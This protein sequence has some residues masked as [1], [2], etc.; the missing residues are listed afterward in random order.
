MI[1]KKGEK[2]DMIFDVKYRP[3]GPKKKV[4]SQKIGVEN[5][6]TLSLYPSAFAGGSVLPVMMIMFGNT[7]EAFVQFELFTNN[8][9][10]NTDVNQPYS[11]MPAL[12]L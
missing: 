7:L 12:E 8:S 1:F 10:N 11:P 4:T 5:L 6:V 9:C 2:E 3:L